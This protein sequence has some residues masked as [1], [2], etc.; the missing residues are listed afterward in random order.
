MRGSGTIWIETDG[1]IHGILKALFAAQVPQRS[2]LCITIFRSSWLPSSLS[3]SLS[4]AVS[5]LYLPNESQEHLVLSRLQ[6]MP[7]LVPGCVS[8]EFGTLHRDWSY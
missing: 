5:T 1:V 8:K 4:S 3:Q 6:P 7:T 2:I